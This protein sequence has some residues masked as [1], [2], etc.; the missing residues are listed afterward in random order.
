MSHS[1]ENPLQLPTPLKIEF[2]NGPSENVLRYGTECDKLWDICVKN[3]C[4]SAA[5]SAY[6]RGVRTLRKELEVGDSNP[7]I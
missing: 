4:S 5:L 1:F 7:N 2:G 3:R 6:Y